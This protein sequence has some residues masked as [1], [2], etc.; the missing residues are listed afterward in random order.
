MAKFF[1]EC[2]LI[3]CKILEQDKEKIVVESDFG[4]FSIFKN[5]NLTIGDSFNLGLDLKKYK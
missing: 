1:G 2:N 3:E 4:K 5:T